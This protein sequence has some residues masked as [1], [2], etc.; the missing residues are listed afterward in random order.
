MIFS[1]A[2][3]E[4]ITG[5]VF[6]RV[7]AEC[8][9]A[10]DRY[11]TPFITP[12][13]AGSSFGG[14]VRREVDPAANRGLD[15]VPQ[16]IT[17]NADEFAW[18]ARLLAEMGY[19][20]VNL[21]LGCPSGTVVA[22]GRGAGLLRDP[23]GL[24]AFLRDVCRASPLPVS[25]KTRLGIQDGAEYGR[26]LEVYLRLPLKELIVHPRVQ[27]DRYQG[28]PRREL[29][30]ETLRRAPF[31]VAYNGD[32]F[33]CGDL[34]ALLSAYPDTRHVMLGR[35]ILANPAL[36]RMLAG[37]PVATADELRRFHDRLFDAYRE[38]IGGNAV[39]RMKEW[40][41]YARFSFA[42]PLSVHR[43]V[44]KV[45]RVDEYADAVER[46]FATEHLARV[47]RFQG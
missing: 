23:D 38:E 35:G 28:V 13:R 31:P 22:K 2:P 34:D 14:R 6:R 24:E 43:A 18:A 33:G 16:L 45:R 15:V 32:V 39:F 26:I 25:V 1:L 47:A 27:R 29:Y 7:H 9:G 41:S 40:W 12:P 44:R 4:G 36:A 10:L 11:Y 17:K 3:M 30:G 5:H 21:N 37:G 8:F 46:V 20:E 19:A 42:D